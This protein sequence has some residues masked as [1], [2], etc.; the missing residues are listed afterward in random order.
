MEYITG[1]A[2]KSKAFTSF[3][4]PLSSILDGIANNGLCLRAI[5]EYDFDVAAG[6]SSKL[7]QMGIPLSYII[8]ADKIRIERI[9]RPDSEFNLTSWRSQVAGK[10]DIR[11]KRL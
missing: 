6:M 10:L 2:Y 9:E 5:H 4:H 7:N 3:S 11:Q 1:K 8:R